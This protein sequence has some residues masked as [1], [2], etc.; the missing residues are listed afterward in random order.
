MSHE[1]IESAAVVG[2]PSEL[3]EEEVMAFVVLKQGA[4]VG[5]REI[6]QYLE[7]RLAYFA[8]PRYIEFISSCPRPRTAR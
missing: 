3:G 6:T 1:G 2:V 7:G 5:P 8:I 4:R